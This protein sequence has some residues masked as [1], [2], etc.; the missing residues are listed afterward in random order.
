[1]FFSYK[2]KLT[3]KFDIIKILYIF[4]FS[5]E[6][7]IFSNF[8]YKNRFHIIYFLFSIVFNLIKNNFCLYITM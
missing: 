8:L 6:F 7:L 4:N 5:F 1:M 3:E 2:K